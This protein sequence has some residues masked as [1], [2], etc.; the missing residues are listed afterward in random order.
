MSPQVAGLMQAPSVMPDR[1]AGITYPLRDCVPFWYGLI[2]Y[3]YQ[4]GSRS[5]DDNQFYTANGAVGPDGLTLVQGRRLEVPI[6]MDEDADFFMQDIHITAHDAYTLSP[7]NSGS[8]DF[9]VP[10]QTN[11]GN[12]FIATANQKI[13]WVRD[14]KVNVFASSY[15]G[16]DIYGGPGRNAT[17]SDFLPLPVFTPNTQINRDGGISVRTPYFLER[18]STL[19]IYLEIT[20][21][22]VGQLQVNGAVRGYK[23]GKRG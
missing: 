17:N 2:R 8:R 11:N 19:T 21:T 10:P 20:N 7:P 9:L 4:Y 13:P 12:P 22:A 6:V 16:R 1:Y 3:P 15:G 5:P 18:A 14:I 23:L